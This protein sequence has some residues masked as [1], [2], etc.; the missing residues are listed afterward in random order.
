MIS[1]IV[2]FR[3]WSLERLEVCI[4][5]LRDLPA[6]SEIILVDFG[7]SEPLAPVPGCRVVRVEADRWCLSEANNIGIA[8]ATNDVIL[9]IDADVRLLVPD[10]TLRQLAQ[11]V[12]DGDVAFYVLQATDFQFQNGRP[13]RKRLRANWGEGCCNLFSRADVIEIGGFDTRFFDYGGED[14]DL[15]Q[16]LRRYG[17]RVE[18]YLSD[19]VM[20]E[21]HPPSE[22][23]ASGRFTD[24]HKKTLLADCSIFRPQPF[25]YS[26]YL[27]EG[28]FGPAITVAIA[29]IDRPNRAEHL[30]YCLNGLAQQT[31]KSFE[32]LI[33]E[34]GS[35]K[36]A[37]LKEAA[38][39]KSFPT[40]DIHLHE[41]DDPSIPKARN[42]ITDRAR[43][44]Y[45]AIHDDDDFSVPTRFEEQMACMAAEDGAHGCHSS[46]VEFDEESGRLTSFLGQARDI[47]QLLRRRGKVT[48][49]SSGFYRLDVLGRVRYDETM[50][51]GSDY[52]L[53]IRMLLAGYEIPHTGKFHCLRRCHDSSV[54]KHGVITQREV[55]DRTN[56]A[57]KY[58]LGEPFLAAVRAEA[59]EGLW[60][61]GFP[62]MREMLAFLPT[63]F[64]AFHIDLDLEAALIL[65]CDPI[66]GAT[67]EGRHCTVEGLDFLPASQGYGNNT[68]LVMRARQALTAGET[69][70]KLP[71]FSG[72]PGVSVVSASELEAHSS[73]QSLDG[74]RV[75]RGQ[76][77]VI[78][79]CYADMTEALSALPASVLSFGL[80]EIE[81]FAVNHPEPGV[82]VLLGAFE[83]VADLN[84]ALGVANAGTV[85]DFFAVTNKGKRGGFNGT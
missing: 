77:R 38:L 17:K 43:G 26:D 61:T 23:Q 58:F 30:A 81:F 83:T 74:L 46:W 63:G 49:H 33:C 5:S 25:R 16:R 24:S 11:T 56:G 2:P 55:S 31:F 57:Y 79:R 21:R 69:L 1:A 39:R 78:S 10:D 73:L 27:D 42:L 54:S 4:G 66:F 35:P 22:P 84:Y 45:I 20:H 85:G 44:F 15:C 37:R 32:V 52:D 62:T 51:L 50:T 48:L 64:G 47:N 8:E 67:G 53:N 29:T 59:E 28:V 68:R 41:L 12:A 72:L 3:N 70:E 7:S 36:A 75:E 34:N 14:N 80:E 40:L 82:H 71:A 9:K 13:S 6:I 18:I 60:V 65:G 19:K 76:R